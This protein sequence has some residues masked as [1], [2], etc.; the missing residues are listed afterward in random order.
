VTDKQRLALVRD[1]EKHLKLTRKGWLEKP[2]G[3]GSEWKAAMKALNALEKDLA[4]AVPTLG[5][6]WSGGAP[7]LKQDL[8]HKTGGIPLYPAFD[9]AFN[10]IG[11]ITIIAPERIIVRKGSSSVPGDAFYAEGDSGLRYWFGHL[12][13]APAVGRVIGKGSR[14]GVTLKHNIGGG[15]HCHCGVNAEK[16]L[17]P[18]K[19]LLYGKTGTGPDYTHGSPTIGVQLAKALS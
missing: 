6:I 18:G 2:Q 3:G 10:A 7:L 1:A 4:V 19:Q 16:F 14:I 11:G 8:T 13:S 5:P 17:G 9:D 15:P 12:V